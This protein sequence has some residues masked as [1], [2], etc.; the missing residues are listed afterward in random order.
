MRE[1]N[2]FI[3]AN[4]TLACRSFFGVG[5]KFSATFCRIAFEATLVTTFP[6]SGIC[7]GLMSAAPQRTQIFALMEI[8]HTEMGSAL[9]SI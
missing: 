7:L 5:A 8:H 4:A 1:V 3:N 2:F 6:H 9:T